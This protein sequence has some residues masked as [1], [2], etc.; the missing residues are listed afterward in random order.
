MHVEHGFVYQRSE[1]TVFFVGNLSAQQR[2]IDKVG[3]FCDLE[4][5]RVALLQEEQVDLLLQRGRVGVKRLG[6]GKATSLC[7]SQLLLVKKTGGSAFC[8]E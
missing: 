5:F 8:C 3:Q 2:I 6:E 7:E 4:L 1:V